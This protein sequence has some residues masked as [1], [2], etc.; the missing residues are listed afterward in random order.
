VK[1]YILDAN[2]IIRY[3][4]QWNDWARVKTL[5]DKARKGEVR[6]LISVVNWGEVIYTMAKHIGL[7]KALT[8]LKT[9]GA[10]LETV[11]VEEDMA[12]EAASLKHN[13]KLGYGDSFAAALAIQ[14]GTTLVSA[15]PDFAKLGK[16]LKWMQLARHSDL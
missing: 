5:F 2:A 3:M 13:F 8:D 14:M 12:E 11:G 4:L 1:P 9:M 6:L 10:V 16:R 15:D 7:A